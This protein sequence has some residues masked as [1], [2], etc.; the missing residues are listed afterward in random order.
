MTRISG[1]NADS[2][3]SLAKLLRA[4][5]AYSNR[6]RAPLDDEG[7]RHVI[8][9]L[10]TGALL[11][12]C[13]RAACSGPRADLHELLGW[14]VASAVNCTLAF[15]LGDFAGAAARVEDRRPLP[16]RT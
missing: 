15:E 14:T 9:E 13:A 2:R 5:N 11:A 16:R 12:R 10:P 1:A 4:T 6:Q 7:H 8:A 3:T